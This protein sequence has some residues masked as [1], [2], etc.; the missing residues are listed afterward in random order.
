MRRENAEKSV[1]NDSLPNRFQDKG[2]LYNRKANL[3]ATDTII[4]QI[5]NF[6]S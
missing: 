2:K 4:K 3:Q 5:D 1:D 6:V